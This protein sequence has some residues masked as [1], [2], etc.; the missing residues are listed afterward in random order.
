MSAISLASYIFDCSKAFSRLDKDRYLI[1]RPRTPPRKGKRN[2]YSIEEDQQLAKF[3]YRYG[4]KARMSEKTYQLMEKKYP[5]HTYQSWKE[6]YKTNQARLDAA[7]KSYAKL[8]QRRR[9]NLDDPYSASET[10]NRQNTDKAASATGKR[11]HKGKQREQDPK[12]PRL[13]NHEN[14]DQDAANYMSK[15]A[16]TSQGR[17]LQG[18]TFDKNVAL[19]S[20]SSH[21]RDLQTS[22]F[23]PS[24]SEISNSPQVAAIR[25]QRGQV[26]QSASVPRASSEEVDELRSSEPLSQDHRKDVV[27]VASVASTFGKQKRATEVFH[28]SEHEEAAEMEDSLPEPTLSEKRA[29]LHASKTQSGR[30]SAIPGK[31]SE[32]HSYQSF[33]RAPVPYI[34]WAPNKASRGSQSHVSGQIGLPVEVSVAIGRAVDENIYNANVENRE[35]I[36]IARQNDEGVLVVLQNSERKSSELPGTPARTTSARTRYESTNVLSATA[37]RPLTSRPLPLCLLRDD[38]TGDHLDTL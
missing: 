26:D 38:W 23:Q 22:P 14:Q 6:R 31:G 4:A 28:I 10:E 1:A 3:L 15:T 18:D 19:A 11:K 37:R 17:E 7:I 33:S 32:S 8:V 27:S 12:R 5:R 21:L 2:E 16:H 25:I 9:D 34:D 30:S 29:M 35:H 36:T 13:V 24:R 20:T